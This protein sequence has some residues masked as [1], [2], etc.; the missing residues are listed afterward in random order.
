METQMSDTIHEETLRPGAMTSL[1][2]RRGRTLRLTTDLSGGVG[3]ANVSALFFNADMPLERYNM[4][5]TLK[6]QFT[7]FLTAGRVLYSDMG[8]VLCSVTA[9][10]CGWHDTL[11]GVI[12]A[13]RTAEKFGPSSYQEARNEWHRNGRDNFLVELAKHGLGRRDLH[14]NVNFFSKVAVDGD[15]NLG[16][17]PDHALP[18]S[19]VDLRAEMNVLAVLSNTP[20]PLA[21]S[22]KEGGAW[23]PPA[24]RL[25]VRATPLPGMEDPCRLSRPENGRGFANTESLFTGETA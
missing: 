7:A 21:P 17:V 1:V 24:V 2:L 15:G 9:D 14:A 19:F 18:G 3:G 10:S 6:A 16:F 20:H 5:D 23:E 13:R 12:D 22:S 11:G 8:R 4:P 25:S